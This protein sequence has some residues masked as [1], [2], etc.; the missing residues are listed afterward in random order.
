MM[1]VPPLTMMLGLVTLYGYVCRFDHAVDFVCNY[2]VSGPF[3]VF[4]HTASTVLFSRL[5][6]GIV[7][8]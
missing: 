3:L 6:P 2:L 4:F 1:F 5:V 8:P 7:V